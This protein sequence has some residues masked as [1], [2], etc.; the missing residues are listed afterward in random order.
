VLFNN[1]LLAFFSLLQMKV[2]S[3]FCN[4]LIVV[5]LNYVVV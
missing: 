4:L 3:V 2:F 1:E 5:V